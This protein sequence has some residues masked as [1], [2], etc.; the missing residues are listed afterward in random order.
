MPPE[1]VR[2]TRIVPRRLPQGVA[3]DLIGGLARVVSC[4]AAGMAAGFGLARIA[5]WYAAGEARGGEMLVMGM[6]ALTG[7]GLGFLVGMV[8]AFRWLQARRS[9]PAG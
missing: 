5:V 4:L 2:G 6:G 7:A 3:W 9:G 1:K 8:W